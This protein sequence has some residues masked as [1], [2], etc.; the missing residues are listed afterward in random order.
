MAHVTRG[1]P[2]IVFYLDDLLV[3]STSVDQHMSDLVALADRLAAHNLLVNRDKLQ[4]GL[5]GAHVL[6]HTL[7][8]DRQGRLCC[9]WSELSRY[10]LTILYIKGEQNVVADYLS[11]PP[12]RPTLSVAALTRQQTKTTHSSP[13]KSTTSDTAT[14]TP[15]LAAQQTDVSAPAAVRVAPGTIPTLLSP[16]ALDAVRADYKKDKLFVNIIAGLTAAGPSTAGDLR[17]LLPTYAL[18]D[19]LLWHATPAGTRL[20][21]PN[22]TTR[23]ELILHIHRRE[24]THLGPA[25]TAELVARSFYF[26]NALTI[27]TRQVA[28]CATCAVVKPLRVTHGLLQPLAAPDKPF[29]HITQDFFGVD[30]G[31]CPER[32][33][34]CHS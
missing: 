25:R 22:G 31:T 18:H 17:I 9:W 28:R 24:L 23:H 34:N 20:A 32:Y 15:L 16:A 13:D 1:L 3:A 21:L 26:P 19:G 8:Q 7:I 5:Q 11:R 27:I 29:R 30:P 4:L 10:S 6:G 2:R 14:H 33:D 12:L